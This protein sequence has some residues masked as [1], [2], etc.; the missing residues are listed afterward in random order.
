ML[1]TGGE[2][3]TWNQGSGVDAVNKGW[4]IIMGRYRNNT[5]F[6]PAYT[7]GDGPSKSNRLR[8]HFT[9]LLTMKLLPLRELV[10]IR[11]RCR[12]QRE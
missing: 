5:Y 1:W 10:A 2:W 8:C 6:M 3:C 7:M 9:L 11:Y 4:S 12:D